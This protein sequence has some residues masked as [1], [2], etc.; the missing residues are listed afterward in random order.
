MPRGYRR[1]GCAYK[2]Q[3][4]VSNTVSKPA[5]T[6][7]AAAS[8]AMRINLVG[9]L[10]RRPLKDDVGLVA[11]GAP[12]A[13][14]ADVRNGFGAKEMVSPPFEHRLATARPTKQEDPLLAG[15]HR[16]AIGAA[17]AIEPGC[18]FGIALAETVGERR[19]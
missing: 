6:A 3:A 5:S 19:S 15:R 4:R 2:Y 14:I 1:L 17:I 10:G 13:D 7:I 9:G 16:P 8:R 12:D 11:E 18:H